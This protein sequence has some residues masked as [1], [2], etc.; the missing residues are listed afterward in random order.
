[1]NIFSYLNDKE[2]LNDLIEKNQSV[3]GYQTKLSE[4]VRCS[5]SFLSQVIHSNVDLTLEHI[6]NLAEYISLNTEEDKTDE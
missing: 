5:R 3:R 4:G 2:F 1:M 6:A